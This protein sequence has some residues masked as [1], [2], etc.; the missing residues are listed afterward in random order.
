ML[1]LPQSDIIHRVIKMS[2]FREQCVSRFAIYS[3]YLAREM[4]GWV[5]ECVYPQI[6]MAMRYDT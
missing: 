1:F 4:V 5:D 6:Q 2:G 3:L